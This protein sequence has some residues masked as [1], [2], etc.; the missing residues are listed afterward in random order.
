MDLKKIERNDD[1]TR[2]CDEQAS[3]GSG[4]WDS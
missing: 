1:R 3:I 2:R 4:D